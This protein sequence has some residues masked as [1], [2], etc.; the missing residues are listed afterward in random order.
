MQSRLIHFTIEADKDAFIT[1]A[2]S[3]DI[4]HRVKSF[5]QFKPEALHRFD[6]NHSEENFPCPR[7]WE[8]TSKLMSAYPEF[9]IEKLPLLAGAIGEGMA[10]EL[11]GFIKIYAELPNIED[12]KRNPAGI[13]MPS[14]PSVQHALTGLVAHHMSV[15]NVDDLMKFVRRLNIDFQ[16]IC[17]KSS[18]AR[19]PEIKSSEAIRAWLVDNAKELA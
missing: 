18:I 14:E 9:P 12:I 11:Y 4:D 8:F 19:N 15:K 3:N 6:P 17:L 1:W 7:T 2:D 16:V 5:I 13:T 10:R